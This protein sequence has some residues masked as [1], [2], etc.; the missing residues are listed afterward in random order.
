MSP[1]TVIS[2]LICLVIIISLI[3]II[4][5]GHNNGGILPTTSPTSGNG[6]LMK[7]TNKPKE[8][9]IEYFAHNWPKLAPVMFKSNC[10]DDCVSDEVMTEFKNRFG[11]Y[12][13]D[14]DEENDPVIKHY[15]NLTY[16]RT[17]K[18]EFKEICKTL[19]KLRDFINN[20]P[21]K[22]RDLRLKD[23]A[24]EIEKLHADHFPQ[25]VFI[26]V[27]LDRMLIICNKFPEYTINQVTYTGDLLTT[28]II[29]YLY[30]PKNTPFSKN[31]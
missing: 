28:S 1:L 24:I 19:N 26:S 25:A 11:D 15:A 23:I 30:L 5:I 14:K 13:K 3:F 12:F 20:Y 16:E 18:M 6:Y 10:D 8:D 21:V 22:D 17:F 31:S 2:I 4:I 27:I 29:Y 9:L 7:K